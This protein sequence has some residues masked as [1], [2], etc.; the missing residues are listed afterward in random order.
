M[1]KLFLTIGLVFAAGIL[2]TAQSPSLDGR[3]MVADPG[4]FPK[5]L[6]AKTVGY[7]PGD[8]ISVTNPSNAE[9]VD[10]LVIGSLDPSEGV[11]IM[12]SPEAAEALNI[13]KNSNNLVKLTKRNGNAD[14]IANGSAVIATNAAGNASAEEEKPLSQV[15]E[16]AIEKGESV[17]DA[18]KEA[19]AEAEE[20]VADKLFDETDQAI[21]AEEEAAAEEE[22]EEAAVAEEIAAEEEAS[23][24]EA[25]EIAAAEEA[26]ETPEGEYPEYEAVED[27]LA[28]EPAEETEEEFVEADVKDD[29]P[30]EE[31]SEEL[32]AEEVPVEEE[33]VEG[34]VV[35]DEYE[36]I[37]LVPSDSK[38][39]ES[40][41]VDEPVIVEEEKEAAI[42]IAPSASGVTYI[43][44]FDELEPQK[45]YVQIAVYKS[46]E[47]VDQI[48]SQYG[49]RYPITVVQQG[50][51]SPVLIG[52]LNVDEYGV[53]L[54]R[55]KSYGFKD[56]FIKRGK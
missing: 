16:E 56:A 30:E 3:A 10:I 40:S 33:P 29:V 8:T 54:E 4:V 7:L 13:K 11:A 6:F 46:A 44:G 36:A 14:E 26:E 22:A 53:A 37:V 18:E 39:P 1:K 51:K 34:E 55:F 24:E 31:L 49:S 12:L 43:R 17:E 52:P 19:I 35:E 48:A 23:E 38:S 21:E 42:E 15:I 9:R 32:A 27:E 25:E 45:Y 5:G 47:N 41:L 28:G 50:G 20:K 2:F